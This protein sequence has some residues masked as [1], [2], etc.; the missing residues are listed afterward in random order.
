[1][2][3]AM[4][5]TLSDSFLKK[6]NGFYFEKSTLQDAGLRIQLGH[7][8]AKCIAPAPGPSKFIIQAFIMLQLTTV[9]VVQMVSFLI[10]S[11]FYELVGFLPLS[12]TPKQPSHFTVLTSIMS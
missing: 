6:W 11:N 4:S 9:I 5:T 7:G 1:M 8:G 3:T 2:N 10:T 12:F